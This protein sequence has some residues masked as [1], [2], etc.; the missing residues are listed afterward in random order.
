MVTVIKHKA[1]HMELGQVTSTSTS[2][3]KKLEET[4]IVNVST[5]QYQFLLVQYANCIRYL[6]VHRNVALD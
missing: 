3:M 5:I 4:T 6:V 1:N 2:Y